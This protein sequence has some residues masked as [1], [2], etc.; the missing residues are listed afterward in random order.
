MHCG[1]EIICMCVSRLGFQNVAVRCINGVCALTGF[2]FKKMYERFAG[3]KTVA[4][5]TR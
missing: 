1:A 3:T 2:Y 5:T 4:V